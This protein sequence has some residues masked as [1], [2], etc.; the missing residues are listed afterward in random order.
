MG[1][2]V[3]IGLPVCSHADGTLCT[4]TFTNVPAVP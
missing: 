4:A 3:F 2:N 1:T